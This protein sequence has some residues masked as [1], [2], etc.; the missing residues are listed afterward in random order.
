MYPVPSSLQNKSP[1]QKDCT[2]LC[3]HTSYKT[4]MASAPSTGTP[5]PPSGAFLVLLCLHT[6]ALVY[7][8]FCPSCVQVLMNGIKRQEVCIRSLSDSGETWGQAWVWMNWMRILVAQHP[9]RG[10]SVRKDQHRQ[11]SAKGQTVMCPECSKLSFCKWRLPASPGP[12]GRWELPRCLTL[13]K[14]SLES[15]GLGAFLWLWAIL[16]PSPSSGIIP[17]FQIENTHQSPLVDV[18]RVVLSELWPGCVPLLLSPGCGL[19]AAENQPSSEVVSAPH[20]PH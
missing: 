2:P 20:E 5:G 14:S 6:T 9:A 10:E 17:P 13:L 4:Q 12:W 11:S 18:L 15:S 3:S 7:F 16:S 1:P 8:Y 19:E